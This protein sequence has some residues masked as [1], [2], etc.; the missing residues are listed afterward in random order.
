MGTDAYMNKD[1]SHSFYNRKEKD[2]IIDKILLNLSKMLGRSPSIE[3]GIIT[4]YSSQVRMIK[5]AVNG[6]HASKD[7]KQSIK[8]ST[9]DG[10]QGGEK[11]IIILSCVRGLTDDKKSN[12]GFLG[13]Y[14]R[15]NVSLTR[16]RQ[17]LWIVGNANIL[18][19]N[20]LWRSFLGS[21]RERNSID[22]YNNFRFDHSTNKRPRDCGNGD[23]ENS[24][25]KRQRNHNNRN[26]GN[27]K[28][29]RKN[30]WNQRGGRGRGRGGGGGDG[31][32]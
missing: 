13:D 3:I 24:N 14:R 8:V 10:F 5:D 19:E 20:K 18:S 29:R 31:F 22:D 2:F 16:A 1:R 4:F 21:L 6:M 27:W 15:V 7:F 25:N 12:V 11:D 23:N 28:Q 30:N 17:S 26:N 32:V 9:V